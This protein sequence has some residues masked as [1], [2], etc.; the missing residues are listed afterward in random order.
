MVTK[1][2][3]SA[4]PF[5]VSEPQAWSG[6]FRGAIDYSCTKA[7]CRDSLDLA[8]ENTVEMKKRTN[9]IIVC[10]ASPS[11][12]LGYDEKGRVP[13]RFT[14]G[15]FMSR[16][17]YFSNEKKPMLSMCSSF[18]EAQPIFRASGHH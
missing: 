9:S 17:M 6:M 12:N 2:I 18:R 7:I 13:R 4:G 11:G 5:S 1:K 3:L 10:G 14:R 16:W 8:V 15:Y